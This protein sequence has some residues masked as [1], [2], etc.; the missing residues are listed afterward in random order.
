MLTLMNSNKSAGKGNVQL[1][2]TETT[3]SIECDQS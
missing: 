1:H 2:R 3:A